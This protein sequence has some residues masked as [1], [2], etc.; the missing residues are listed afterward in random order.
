ML[1]AA[2]LTAPA[3]A[4]ESKVK[5]WRSFDSMGCMMLRECTKDVTKSK[6]GKVL[7]TNMNLLL[8]RLLIFSPV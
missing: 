7:V 5:S 6:L 3:I 4:D 8:K 2:T 1:M